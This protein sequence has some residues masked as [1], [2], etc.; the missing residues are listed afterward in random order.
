MSDISVYGF[1]SPID[2]TARGAKPS[3]GW[4]AKRLI[5]GQEILHQGLDFPSPVGT[6]VHAAADGVVIVS[7]DH[8]SITGKWIVIQH[9]NGFTSRYLHLKKR[10]VKKGQQVRRGQVIAYS[11]ETD[12]IGKPHLHFD[13]QLNPVRLAEVKQ[14]VGPRVGRAQRLGGKLLGYNVPGEVFLPLSS[15]ITYAAESMA[16][17]EPSIPS[18]DQEVDDDP[19]AAAVVTI[20]LGIGAVVG[21]ATALLVKSSR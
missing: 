6:A 3:Q 5:G 1:I 7:Q 12:S 21:L 14:A 9:D 11:G 2:A 18:D 15:A 17:G 4:Y 16:Q 19:P 13:F 20:S 8:G 10:L